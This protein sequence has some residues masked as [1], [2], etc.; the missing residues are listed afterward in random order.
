MCTAKLGFASK[1]TK[2]AMLGVVLWSSM[3][4]VRRSMGMDLSDAKEK[5]LSIMGSYRGTKPHVSLAYDFDNNR[6]EAQASMVS[7]KS[8]TT[9]ED[10]FRELINATVRVCQGRIQDHK[11]QIAFEESMI[12]ELEGLL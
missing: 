10:A 1:I 12:G 3:V 5:F 2:L 8:H 11:D 7:G 6:W 4:L 9:P